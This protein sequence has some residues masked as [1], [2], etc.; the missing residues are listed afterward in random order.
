MVVYQRVAVFVLLVK[1][2]FLFGESWENGVFV[3]RLLACDVRCPKIGDYSQAFTHMIH[4]NSIYL[5][6]NFTIK[7]QP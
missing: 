6:I 5:P 1:C 3:W 2:A 7:N 4:G